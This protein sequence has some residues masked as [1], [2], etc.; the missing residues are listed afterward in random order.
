M[1]YVNT[2]ATHCA[3]I[4]SCVLVALCALANIRV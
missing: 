1:K 2:N 3:P 4:V